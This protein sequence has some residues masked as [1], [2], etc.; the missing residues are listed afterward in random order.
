[1]VYLQNRIVN[2]LLPIQPGTLPAQY[3]FTSWQQTLLDF[4]NNMSAVLENG[5]SYYNYGDTAPAPE[6][7]I[8]PWL[9]SNNMLW[10]KFSGQ[11]ITPHPKRPGAHD[12]EEFTTENEIWSWEGGDG[13][14][15]STSPPTTTAGA[16]WKLDVNYNGRS[17][18]SP[19]VIANAN[20]AKTLSYGENFG[21]GAHLQLVEEVG[22]HPH[23]I[24]SQASFTH[25]GVVDVVSSSSA[26]DDGLLIGQSGTLSN[27]LAV[28][29]NSYTAGQQRGNVV[30]PVRGMCCIVRTGRLYYVAPQPTV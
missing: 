10:Y 24:S 18:M 5:R 2:I 26:S 15:P 13:S 9:N 27:P 7:Q 16:M 19:G 20:P 22:P 28:G 29:I 30:H 11:W 4:A 14:D 23:P 25:D 3:C 17:P 1:M 21:E 8:Y 12:W 6:F